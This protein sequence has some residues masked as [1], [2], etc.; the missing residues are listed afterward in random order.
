MVVG[1]AKLSHRANATGCNER[2]GREGG[3]SWCSCGHRIPNPVLQLRGT[4]QHVEWS[5]RFLKIVVSC[6]C[7]VTCPFYSRSFSF[8]SQA[9]CE[10]V[11]RQSFRCNI[12]SPTEGLLSADS[13]LLNLNTTNEQVFFEKEPQVVY[14]IF[15]GAFLF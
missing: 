5:S 2:G 15:V 9:R 1:G 10:L 3:A 7:I 14:V 8:D 12:T 13:S 6:C 11:I 4:T